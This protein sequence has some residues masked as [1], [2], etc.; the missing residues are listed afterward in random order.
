MRRDMRRYI[1]I[2][3]YMYKLI[4]T[5]LLISLYTCLYIYKDTSADLYGYIYIHMHVLTVVSD[6]PQ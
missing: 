1:H 2:N 4:H 5:S 6:T 3:V